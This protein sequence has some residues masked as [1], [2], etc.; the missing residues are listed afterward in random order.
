MKKEL[1]PTDDEMRALN[2]AVNF[3]HTQ[4][5]DDAAKLVKEL[6][7]LQLKLE[8]VTGTDYLEGY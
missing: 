6:E 3:Y 2:S 5:C 4:E 8:R 7:S 1:I